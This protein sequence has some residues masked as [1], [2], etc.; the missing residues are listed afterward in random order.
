V[1]PLEDPGRVDLSVDVD[2]AAL[3]HAVESTGIAKVRLSFATCQFPGVHMAPGLQ[4]HGPVTQAE[5]LIAMG[6]G[7]RLEVLIDACGDDEEAQERLYGEATRLLH[8]DEMGEV[9][10][11]MAI[12]KAG[13][14]CVGVSTTQ[15][16][17][18]SEAE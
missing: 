6:I 10:K 16:A 11:V 5:F 4:A 8:A 7:Q 12:S 1:D 13:I 3:A 17:E 15:E 14:E 9:Y 18:P 2:F